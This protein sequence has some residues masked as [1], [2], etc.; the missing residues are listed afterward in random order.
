MIE[1]RMGQIQSIFMEAKEKGMSFSD[2]N[3][4]SVELHKTNSEFISVAFEGASMGIAIKSIETSKSLQSWSKFHDTYCQNHSTQVMLGL[5]WALS[6]L[7]LNP[8]K[9]IENFNRMDRFSVY[10]GYGYHEGRFKKRLSIRTQQT[11]EGFNTLALRS[12]DQGLG[13]SFWNYSKGNFDKIVKLVSIF[14]EKRHVDLWRGVGV[15][16]TYIH[17]IDL[18]ELNKLVQNDAVNINGVKAGVALVIKSRGKANTFTKETEEIAQMI[19]EQSCA[20]VAE[21]IS[22]VENEFALNSNYNYNDWISGIETQVC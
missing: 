10:D 15:S 11:P 17:G 12:Y 16:I 19:L 20:E 18:S 6:E 8:S 5:G 7:N 22:N 3:E 14:P 1:E 13:R 21:K 9:Y 4:L 2:F